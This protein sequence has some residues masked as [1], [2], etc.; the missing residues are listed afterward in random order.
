VGLVV[1]AE[2]LAPGPDQIGAVEIIS[3]PAL[4]FERR[5]PNQKIGAVCNNAIEQHP[6]RRHFFEEVERRR[7]FRPHNQFGLL[8]PGGQRQP[9]VVFDGRRLEGRLPFL[10]LLDVA[11]NDRNAHRRRRG[12]QPVDLADAQ[13]PVG[14]RQAD[15][16]RRCRNAP[17]GHAP[18]HRPAPP[19][20]AADDERC[21]EE[22]GIGQ[23]D[24]P[25]NAVHSDYI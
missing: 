10:G 18:G 6:G 23:G 20:L 21:Q 25:G 7:R 1:C 12:R 13:L 11:L 2:H 15:Q 16:H 22:R 5:G 3:G 14:P 9:D 24:Q 17:D 8:R 4:Q 19:C